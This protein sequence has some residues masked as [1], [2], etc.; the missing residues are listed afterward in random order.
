VLGLVLACIT[1]KYLV[2]VLVFEKE[3]PLRFKV[4]VVT[5]PLEA[6]AFPEE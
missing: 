1:T 3:R 4:L 2:S 5:P 6:I